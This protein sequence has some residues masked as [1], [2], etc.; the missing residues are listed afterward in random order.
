MPNLNNRVKKERCKFFL[1]LFIVFFALIQCTQNESHKDILS[2]ALDSE[3]KTLDPRKS[4]EAYGIRILNLIF[5]GLVRVGPQLKI[6]PDGAKKW[7]QKGRTYTFTLKP[8]EFSNGRQV[9]QEDI[10]F[11]FKEFQKKGNPFAS[12]FKNIKKVKVWNDKEELKVQIHLKKISA[13]FL[14]A[15]LPVLKILPKKEIEASAESFLKKPFGTGDFILEEKT[16]QRI[17]LKRRNPKKDYP[18]F[19][20]FLILR[21]NVTRV[22]KILRGDID[23]SPSVIPLKKISQ[24]PTSRFNVFAQPSLSTTYVLINLKHK[25]LKQKKVREALSLALDRKQIIKYQLKDYGLPATSFLNPKHFTLYKSLSLKEDKKIAQ[26]LIKNLDLKGTSLILSTSNNQ[27]TV[28]KAKIL[29][30]QWNQIGLRVS[31][32]S[33]EW[34]TFYQDL[35]K[36]HFDLALMKWVGVTDPDIYRVA[37]H[38]ENVAP[39]GRNRSFYAN[40]NLDV[41]LEQG[42]KTLKRK[43]RSLIY[44][45]AQNL[46]FKNYIV[47]PLW[48]EKEISVVKKSITG[49]RMMRNGGFKTLSLV[50][51]GTDF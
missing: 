32:E 44:K 20:S 45:K 34:G 1:Y 43:E 18:T 15:D 40:K 28:E 29:I 22:Q 11:S 7:S 14:S 16:S 35:N 5:H 47:L 24:F 6:L 19:L 48:H 25:I 8:L 51:K 13:T 39:Q 33:Y 41:L 10:E 12:A 36:G 46:I 4:T 17:L 31:L 30:S 2:I 26:T 27:D 38:S 42:L 21:D 37:F 3:P 50:K 9:T 23:I 49:Y